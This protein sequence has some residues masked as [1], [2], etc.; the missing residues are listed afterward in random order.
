MTSVEEVRAMLEEAG[1]GGLSVGQIMA[2]NLGNRKARNMTV[3]EITAA[4]RSIG[5]EEF[6]I[7]E[8]GR[9][10]WEFPVFRLQEQEYV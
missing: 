5:A 10:R 4:L 7:K 6:H 3:A 2:L 9:V 8:N 1:P